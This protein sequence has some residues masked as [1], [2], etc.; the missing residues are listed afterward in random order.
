MKTLYDV[1]NLQKIKSKIRN[2]FYLFLFTCILI[3]GYIFA[4]NILIAGKSVTRKAARII[5]VPYTNVIGIYTWYV[6]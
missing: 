6:I 1:A 5:G 3:T 2:Q 4:Q